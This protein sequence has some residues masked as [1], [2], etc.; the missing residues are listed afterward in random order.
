M[1]TAV[2]FQNKRV[3]DDCERVT[4]ELRQYY[5]SNATCLAP[6]AHAGA[7]M[8]VKIAARLAQK[9]TASASTRNELDFHVK[10]T[11]VETNAAAASNCRHP[12]VQ[13][14]ASL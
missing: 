5:N 8:Q 2:E 14:S 9:A 1:A 12:L 4:N 13:Q 3:N 10:R 11:K 7:H 6:I